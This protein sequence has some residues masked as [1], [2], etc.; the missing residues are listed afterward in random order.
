MSPVPP[1]GQPSYQRVHNV[2][3][4]PFAAGPRYTRVKTDLGVEDPDKQ[5]RHEANMS[6]KEQ[7]EQQ[8]LEKKQRETHDRQREDLEERMRNAKL[9]RQLEYSSTT[10]L[11][12][13]QK[14]TERAPIPLDLGP[15][16]D[17][18]DVQEAY[19]VSDKQLLEASRIPRIRS[20]LSTKPAVAESPRAAPHDQRPALPDILEKHKPKNSIPYAKSR[21]VGPR[22]HEPAKK[23]MPKQ[24]PPKELPPVL[25]SIKSDAPHD[26]PA[27]PKHEP[28]PKEVPSAPLETPVAKRE[29]VTAPL[30]PANAPAPKS[31]QPL[32]KNTVKPH[33]R[34]VKNSTGPNEME[35][36]REQNMEQL[37][38][39]KQVLDEKRQQYV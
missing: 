15:V 3:P 19:G 37:L 6:W 17:V 38:T 20:K 8:I 34:I 32:P 22:K 12:P 16:P 33:Q 5:L 1:P 4:P 18:H 13:H 7:I 9:A 27:K 10:P 11:P 39:L 36:L 14:P 24:L 30:P 26:R 29:T 25:P 21:N 23:E 31:V 2:A 28:A 35:R